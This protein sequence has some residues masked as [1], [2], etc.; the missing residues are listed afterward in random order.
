ML[1]P[2]L[3]SAP[4]RPC[5]PGR[6]QP[7]DGSRATAAA[8]LQLDLLAQSPPQLAVAFRRL[9]QQVDKVHVVQ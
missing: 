9:H 8:L 5:P 4:R 7:R 2:A 3:V 1:V 6:T